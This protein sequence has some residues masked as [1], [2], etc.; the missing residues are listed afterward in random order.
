MLM[1]MV[2][3]KESLLPSWAQLRAGWKNSTDTAKPLS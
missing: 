2:L 3:E 1:H